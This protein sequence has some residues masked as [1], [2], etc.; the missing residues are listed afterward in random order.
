MVSTIP[1]INFVNGV[2][3][4]VSILLREKNYWKQEKNFGNYVIKLEK[5]AI[6]ML[7]FLLVAEKT[8]LCLVLKHKFKMNPLCVF[9]EPPLFTKLGQQN[10]NNFENAGFDVLRISQNKYYRKMEKILFIELGLPQN[11]WLALVGVAPMRVAKN[12]KIKMIMWGE[13]GE[14]MYGGDNSQKNKI[15]ARTDYFFKTKVN[16]NNL[17]KYIKK[18][19][20]AKKDYFWSNIEDNEINQFSSILK[21]HWSYFEK[22]MKQNT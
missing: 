10:L 9:C 15:S 22:W 4:H 5:I 11:N 19:N 17:S 2:C 7:L 6:T 21:C 18:Y 1:R 3:S 20:L 16:K 12:L 14:S 13:D 8:V